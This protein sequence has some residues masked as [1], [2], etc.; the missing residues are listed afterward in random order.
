MLGE[1]KRRKVFLDGLTRAMSKKGSLEVL[2]HGCRVRGVPFKLAYFR[3]AHGLNPEVL[4]LY[5]KNRL[6]VVRQLYYDPKNKN[7]IDLVL[8]L[9]GVPVVTAEL[10]META[11]QNYKN[12]IGQ[13]KHD[14]DA[15]A[16]IF[17]FKERALVHFAIDSDEAHM[18]TRLAGQSTYFL[19]FNKGFRKGAG[20]PPVDGK[21]RTHYV[22]EEVWQRDS[23]LQIIGRFMN[24]Q[25]DPESGKETMIFPRY[26]QLD[27]VRKLVAATKG[28][29][30]GKN[31]LVQHSTGSGKSMSIAWLTHQLQSL[32]DDADNKV[33]DSVVV[34]TDRLVLD[35]QLQETIYQL[36]HKSGVVEQIDQ[37]STQLAEAL[38]AGAPII[39]TTLHKFPYVTE[40]IGELPG[41]N[42]AVVVDEAHSSQ[43]GEMAAEMKKI[44]SGKIDDDVLREFEDIEGDASNADV[45]AA[46]FKAA[47]YRG[48]RPNLSF[49]AFTATPKYK[50]LKMFDHKREG[51][52]EPFHL[53]SMKQA[54]EEGFILDT[55]EKYVTY[56]TYFGLVKKIED[57]KRL[58]KRKGS[59]ALARFLSLH[60]HNVSQK[61]EIIVEHFQRNTRK[62]IDGRAKAMVVCGSRLHA[63]RY[64]LA[65]D[66]Y[67]KE[68]GYKDLGV[69]VAFSGT[70]EDPDTGQ[71]YTEEGMN[72]GIKE[73]ELPRKFD[74]DRYRFLIV[75]NKYQ[76][77]FD[78]PKLHTMYVDKRLAHIQ[79]VQTLSRLNR[80]TSGKDDTFVLDF[81]NKREEILEAF[82]PFYE[83]TTI[84]EDIDPQKL[85]DLQHDLQEFRIFEQQEVE[86]FAKI[87]FK[88]KVSKAD[89]GRLN[90]KLDPAVTRFKNREEEEQDDFRAMLNN[91]LRL[92]SFMAQ[93]EEWSDAQ[94]EMLYVYGRLLARKLPR[95]NEQ[96]EDVDIS[97]DV[98]L[99]YYR[100]QQTG[101]GAI[102]L[103][104]GGTVSGP[105]EVGTGAKTEEDEI[106]LSRLIDVLN[107]RFGTDFSDSDEVIGEQWAAALANRENVRRAAQAN[108]KENFKYPA[109]KELDDVALESHGNYTEFVDKFFSEDEFRKVVQ[110]WV[111][112]R[113]F[114]I[115]RESA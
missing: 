77:G 16:P 26:H 21:H 107:E 79:A 50:T 81:V 19:P 56:K 101:E 85:Y 82:K 75:A 8:F 71:S 25:V 115:A 24:L 33:F 59:K 58:D 10:K 113:A 62:K 67:I 29:G 44:L 90:S 3:P 88:E 89:N 17:R 68:H 9:N 106:E 27:C 69:L 46:A 108:T 39:I 22:W 1:G 105:L 65:F 11:G 53:Y 12:A 102:A 40:K 30:P 60:P 63:V 5:E 72:G 64:K 95:R 100:I 99:K 112:D 76:T 49:Y 47:L 42:Y 34:V 13:Y 38:E 104:G 78:Q 86:A 74:T 36:E 20:N 73:G 84:D 51:A 103:E 93:V 54:I 6:T 35:K 70:V 55:L 91:Y 43:S 66:A 15:K 109:S 92:Y 23:L 96:T 41:N 7:S 98:A 14:R 87:F 110:E 18:T 32:H 4:E 97:D 83:R 31:Y 48:P 45:Y 80:T 94:L 2:R 114:D 37:D 28:N 57:D 111:L 52:P 61:T